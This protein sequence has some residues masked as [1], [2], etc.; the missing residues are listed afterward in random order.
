M[1]PGFV[2]CPEVPGSVL[3]TEPRAKKGVQ[4]TC[5][6]GIRVDMKIVGV[7]KFQGP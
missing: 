7:R 3:A 1:A 2:F 6:Q 5:C 4:G